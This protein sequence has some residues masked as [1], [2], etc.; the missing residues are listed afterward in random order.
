[1]YLSMLAGAM[2]GMPIA[3]PLICICIATGS[4]LCYAL[5][6]YAGQC[7]L[8]IPNWEQRIQSWR[9]VVQQYNRNILTYLTL[10]R[11]VYN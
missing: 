8:V 11:Y 1:M 2:W 9:T 10:L 6:S 5:S 3:L 7:L 4:T